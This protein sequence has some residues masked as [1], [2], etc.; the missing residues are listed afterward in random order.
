MRATVPTILAALVVSAAPVSAQDE[1][2]K[3][4]PEQ[5]GQ[6]FCISRLGNDMTPTEALMTPSLSA[7]IEEAMARNAAMQHAVPD[8]KPPLGD[9]VPWQS[10]PDYAAR[11]TPGQVSYEMDEA[12]VE[13]R[14]GFPEAPRANYSDTLRLRLVPDPVLGGT[15]WRI[16]DIAYDTDG[17]LRQVLESAF[18]EN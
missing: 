12:G 3:I 18:L 11:C 17:T 7:A 6:I 15:R 2:T 10:F 9:G 16:D 14:Y 5:I 8:E 13:I 4:T 1:V